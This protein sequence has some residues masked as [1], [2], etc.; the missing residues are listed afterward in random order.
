MKTMKLATVLVLALV[1]SGALG[2]TLTWDNGAADGLWNTTSNNWGALWNNATPDSAIFGA[3][4][5]GTVTL[6]EA[7]TVGDITFNTAGYTIAGGGFA[8]TPSASIFT[9][10][11]DATISAVL[12]GTGTVTKAGTG[13]LVLS[14]ANTWTGATA[15]N[16]GTLEVTGNSN[17]KRIYTVAAGATLK[18]GYQYSTLWG[19]GNGVRVD[20][21]GVSDA[22]G[23]YL[24]GGKSHLFG[25]TLTLQTAASTVRGYGTGSAILMGGDINGTHL[26]VTADASG[27]VIDSNVNLRSNNYGYH[28]NIAAGTETATGDV[29]VQ[30]TIYD[31]GSINRTWNDGILRPT[32]FLKDGTGSIKL[33]GTSTSTDIFSVRAGSLILSGGDDRI[34][35]GGAVG[36]GNGTASGKL[37]LGDAG[38]AVNQTLIGLHSLGTGTAN[39]AVGGSAD[40]STLTI[41][42]ADADDKVISAFLGGGGTNENQLALTKNGA[43]VLTLTADNTYDGLTTVNAGTLEVQDRSGDTEYVVNQDATLKI[44][45]TSGGGYADSNIKVY[46]DGAAATTGLYLEGGDSYNANGTIQLLTDATTI[47]QYGTG[48][49]SIGMFDINGTGIDVTADASGSVIDANIQMVSRGYGMSIRVAA[50]VNTATGDLILNGPMNVNH[51]TNGFYKRGDGSLVINGDAT[52]V[53]GLMRVQAGTMIVNGDCSLSNTTTVSSGAKLGGSGSV[54]AA[55]I[56]AGGTIAPGNSAGTFTAD[57]LDIDGTLAYEVDGVASDLLVVVND[58]DIDGATLAITDLGGGWTGVYVVAQYGSLTGSAFA[59]V[60]G[61]DGDYTVVYDYNG[62]TEIALVPEPATMSLLALGG[63]AML[64][65]RK[66]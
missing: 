6:G 27:S 30:G 40:M 13:T 33:T 17:T 32:S 36:L 14:G 61:L 5:V 52:D 2:A 51:Q 60:T 49:V 57:S 3:T 8:L 55:V 66:K 1:A 42:N 31:N 44:G 45:Y 50:G 35:V 16:A 4:G 23:L 24:D 53:N 26:S 25:S 37:I 54:G 43:G 18:I 28:A 15:I 63:I 46:G 47:R 59:S 20:G 65:R 34:A 56:N 62:G 12:D 10:N 39:A 29:T 21:N 11:V 64:K 7:T 19:G 9:A 48:L 41:N 38:G 22:S 58:L